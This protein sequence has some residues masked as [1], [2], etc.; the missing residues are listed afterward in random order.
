M[1]VLMVILYPGAQEC[2][3]MHEGL[4]IVYGCSFVEFLLYVALFI[5]SEFCR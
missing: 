3:A 5:S 1:T 2:A 4:R